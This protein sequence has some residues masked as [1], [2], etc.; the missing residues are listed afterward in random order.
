MQVVDP[1]CTPSL[2]KIKLNGAIIRLSAKYSDGSGCNKALMRDLAGSGSEQTSSSIGRFKP[3]FCE[4][5]EISP[6]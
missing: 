3:D 2:L 1:S 4:Q 6:S 5:N